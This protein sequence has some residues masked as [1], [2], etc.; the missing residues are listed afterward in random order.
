MARNDQAF[1]WLAD[2]GGCGLYRIL[3]PFSQLYK[4][5]YN[6]AAN[7]AFP[8]G[9]NHGVLVG[10]RVS[11]TKPSSRWQQLAKDDNYFLVYETDDDLFNIDPSNDKAY[12]FFSH[13]EIEENMIR[14]VQVA[15]LV[16]VTNEYL[17]DQMRRYNK[18]VKILPN[19]IDEKALTLPHEV[20]RVDDGKGN[21]LDLSEKVTIGYAGSPSHQMDFDVVSDQLIKL[22]ER[23]ERVIFV[24]LGVRY[25]IA[26][27]QIYSGWTNDINEY[28]QRL[29]FDI[30]IAPLAKHTFNNSKS[31]IKAL[32]YG[33]RGIPIVASDEPPYRDFV[34]HGETG[35]LAKQPYQFLKY[36]RELVNDAELRKEMGN[37]AREYCAQFTI[38]KNYQLWAD[39]YGLEKMPAE[40]V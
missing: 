6:V 2:H 24:W 26:A 5:G 33:C 18:N 28:Y 16:T 17:A 30:G 31:Y 40:K 7:E 1:G 12:Y 25:E 36:L 9:Y 32:E 22:A 29:N 15:D 8:R 38:Q 10:Q 21:A 4:H 14:N 11:K 34:K 13:P 23:D 19:F 35:F 39:A 20:L 3:V 27:P 37:K